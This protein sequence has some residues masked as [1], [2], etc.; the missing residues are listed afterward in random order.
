MHLTSYKAVILGILSLGVVLDA[1]LYPVPKN[2]VQMSDTPSLDS[3]LDST[4]ASPVHINDPA[5]HTGREDRSP[6]QIQIESLINQL[7]VAPIPNV[8]RIPELAT[9]ISALNTVPRTRGEDPLLRKLV[10]NLIDWIDA[11]NFGQPTIEELPRRPSSV[12]S[13][14]ARLQA[15][16]TWKPRLVI[17]HE[18]IYRRATPKERADQLQDPVYV[19]MYPLMNTGVTHVNV[20]AIELTDRV[21]KI[22]INGAHAL[23]DAG[24]LPLY[25]EI[26]SLKASGIKFL[27]RLGGSDAP[28]F[29]TLQDARNFPRHFQVLCKFI[30]QA[31]LD[32]IDLDIREPASLAIIINLIAQLKAK[33]G[34]RFLISFSVPSTA[35][36]TGPTASTNNLA[37]FSY[38]QLER[39]MGQ[40]IDYYNVQ[41][42]C[43]G[44]ADG[45]ARE[46]AALVADGWPP[47]KIVLGV[48]TRPALSAGYLPMTKL[49]QVI[50]TLGAK[51][52]QFGGV[53]AWE[54]LGSSVGGLANESWEWPECVGDCLSQLVPSTPTSAPIPRKTVARRRIG[55]P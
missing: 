35:L 11:A 31:G 51:Y 47:A 48:C 41:F 19:S 22:Y 25:I 1:A 29:A 21:G 3:N 18:T 32:G 12:D 34:A 15:R 30:D 50:K 44:D 20:G 24:Y 14:P 4:A 16:D 27:G 10:N 36:R 37:G 52:P 38:K 40:F 54:L 6:I 8:N 42:Y 17:Y 7:K 46:Y 55:R 33:Y 5:L 45:S 53:A 2:D 28:T 43:N 23:M 39:E 49:K 13:A 26:H 9:L